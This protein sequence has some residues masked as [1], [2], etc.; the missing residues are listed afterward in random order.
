MNSTS[1]RR[2]ERIMYIPVVLARILV[3]LIMVARII[4]M[5]I[6]YSTGDI[7]RQ[8]LEVTDAGRLIQTPFSI[9]CMNICDWIIIAL[10]GVVL[11]VMLFA[12]S[13][14][15]YVQCDMF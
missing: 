3:S 4:G 7:P 13:S 2:L 12:G 11:P 9:G 14:W 8:C 10:S 15:C 6:Q 1:D 5:M